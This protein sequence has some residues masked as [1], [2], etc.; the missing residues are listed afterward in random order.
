MEQ[1]KAYVEW[2]YHFHKGPGPSASDDAIVDAAS[3][4]TTQVSIKS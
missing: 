4:I 3:K 2:F 1:Y